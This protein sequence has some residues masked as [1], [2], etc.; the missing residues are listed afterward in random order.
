MA[1][2][3]IVA[4]DMGTSGNKAV[5]FTIYGNMVSTAHEYYPM[6]HP[7]PGYAEQ[8]PNDWLDAVCK[9]TR[10]VL[11]KR[12]IHPE[13]VAGI[14]FSS[15]TQTLVP[16]SKDGTPLRR[17]ISW[18][19]G[20]S[21]EIMRRKLWTPPRIMR[22][23]IFKL[24]KFLTITGGSPGH[25]GKDQ[26]G[27]ILW[28]HEHE[29]DLFEKTYKFID[30]KDFILYHLTGNMVTSVDLAVIWW[31]LDT[32][33][34][35]NQWHPKLCKLA[36]ITTEKLAEVR[37]SA[38]VIGQLTPEMAKRTGLL[39]GT[40][41][42]NGAGDLSAEALGSGAIGEGELHISLGTSGWVAGHFTKRKI[43]LAHYTGCIGSAYPQKYY[44]GMAHQETAAICLEW[45]KNKV[46]YHEEQLKEEHHV[47]DI[48]K[49]LDQLAEKAGPGAGG[50]MFT[51]W[52]YGERCPLDDDFVRAGLFNIGLN[53][54]REHII[55]AVFEGI[56]F[57][58]R[59]AMET[60]ENLFSKVVSLNI[61]GGG[62][63]SDV[64]CQIIADISNRVINR[65]ADPQQAGARGV[66]LLASMTLG[67]I[68]SYEDIKKYIKIDQTFTPNPENRQL[69]D[70]LFKEFKNIYKQN[71]RWYARMNRQA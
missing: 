58:T 4:H 71:K 46:L 8:N 69:Y 3:Y 62:A 41:V 24:L 66:A 53:H 23:N 50:L 57:N 43:D 22:Y 44:L 34:N 29:P 18:L 70:K 9:T 38:E 52:M 36:G 7:H 63:Q 33:K 51:P 35:R 27:K 13:D 42:I 47:P 25:T 26:I 37:E 32:R 64:W 6:F 31:F 59:W 20:R 55:R 15:C 40:P 19:D 11:E 45:L 2:K 65:V 67:Y 12:K 5:L 56:S 49:I 10:A 16:V 54:S 21:A 39:P 60:L 28:M 1:E 17:A 48:Y 14:T 30:A 68:D 61:I